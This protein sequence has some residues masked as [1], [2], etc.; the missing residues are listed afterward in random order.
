VVVGYTRAD[1]GEFIGDAGTSHLGALLPGA[2]DPEEVAA[3]EA[4]VA[5]EGA[6]LPAPAGVAGEDGSGFSTGGDRRSLR[7]KPEDEALIAAVS[8]HNPRTVVVV[9]AGSAVVME[10]WRHDVPTIVQLW[11]SGMEGGHALADV[12]LGEVDASGRLPFS[13]PTDEAHLPPFEPDADAVVYDGWHGY[14]HLAREGHAPAYPFGFGLSYTSWEVGS[15]D[16]RDDGDHLVVR[17][18]LRNTGDRDG[19]DVVQ[20]YGGR[21]ADPSRPARRLVGF[22][23]AEVAAGETAVVELEVPWARLAVRDITTHRWE[24]PAG[25]YALSVGRHAGDTRA[26]EVVIERS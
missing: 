13:I 16:V 6:P 15:A 10:S 1:E 7:L 25:S 12:L 18:Q 24:V 9:I 17:A 8:A 23:R 21:P 19:T 22:A 2:D 20:V 14:W 11:Y 3:F 5:A 4:R 26:V